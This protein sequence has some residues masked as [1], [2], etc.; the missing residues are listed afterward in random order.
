[1][2]D[3]FFPPKPTRIWPDADLFKSLDQ[4]PNWIGEIKYNGWRLL[5]FKTAGTIL[6]KNNH[7][8]IIDINP[9]QFM[10]LFDGVPDNTIFDGEL[11]DKRTK[12]LKNIMVF[13]DC[14]FY[15]GKDL[16]GLPLKT[17]RQYLDHFATTPEK[18]VQKSKAQVYKV[19]QF[20]SGNLIH[21]YHQVEARANALEEGI[22]LKNTLSK[23]TSHPK[24]CLDI[25]DWIKV[26]KPG[27]DTKV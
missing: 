25:I 21:L 13:W 26:K 11:V 4:N 20:R 6:I 22:V 19:N 12:D 2:I 24:R 1:V 23:Y 15:K 14:C 9:T 7:G 18:I 3:F 16:R 5:L 8:S 17:R 10:P 27:E